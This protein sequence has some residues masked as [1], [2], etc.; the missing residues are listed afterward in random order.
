MVPVMAPSTGPAPIPMPSTDGGNG[1]ADRPRGR[2]GSDVIGVVVRGGAVGDDD[3][4]PRRH[5]RRGGG[6]IAV[7]DRMPRGRATPT[8]TFPSGGGRGVFGR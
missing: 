7:N 5:G 4:D 3:C 1:E 2:G 6:V 8:G